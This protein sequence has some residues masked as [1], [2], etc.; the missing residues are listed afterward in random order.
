VHAFLG[1][2]H[3]TE[4]A[5]LAN[6]LL[7][8]AEVLPGLSMDTDLRWSFV[9]TLSA[10][11]AFTEEQIAAEADRDP[12][13]AGVRAAATSRALIPTAAAKAAAWKSATEDDELPNA[14]MEAII[15][16]FAHPTQGALLAPYVARYFDTVLKVWQRR[17]SEVAQNVV[18]GLFPS[19][20]STIT[21]QTVAAADAFLAQPDLPA[22][23]RRL[24]S[25]GRA[26]IVRAI[27]AR[28]AD[29]D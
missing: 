12:T 15:G 2:A 10:L 5:A 7:T 13:A 21:P 4:H 3:T 17:S 11:G 8:G 25:E 14:T 19:W 6:D 22:A 1:A 16:G 9:A 20:T 28:A 27:K 26:D 23:V 18:V 29:I 24:V